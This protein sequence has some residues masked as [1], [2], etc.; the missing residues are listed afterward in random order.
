[1]KAII[2]IALAAVLAIP[3]SAEAKPRKLNCGF[4]H[5]DAACSVTPPVAPVTPSPTTAPVV[6]DPTDTNGI[7]GALINVKGQFVSDLTAVATMSAT[8]N[9]V[10]GESWDPTALWCLNGTPAVGTAGQPGFVPAYPGL[11][12]WVNG[13]SLPVAMTNPV[14]PVPTGGG[15]AANAEEAWL[16]AVALQEA[17]VPIVNGIV[18]Q[19]NSMGPPESVMN[20]CGALIQ[21]RIQTVQN[22]VTTGASQL[23]LFNSVLIKYLPQAALLG[24][25]RMVHRG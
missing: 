20:P 13:L 7:I 18:A 21:N 25:V 24:H 3:A 12:A 8:P 22:A 9:A 1:M 2:G 23:A 19:L 11:I 16:Q 5:P 6:A 4:P 10:T 15:I 17:S 14:P